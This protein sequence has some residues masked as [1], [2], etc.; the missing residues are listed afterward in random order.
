MLQGFSQISFTRMQVSYQVHSTRLLSPAT[1]LYPRIRQIRCHS[2]DDSTF[3]VF[4]ADEPDLRPQLMGD[5]RGCPLQKEIDRRCCQ[6]LGWKSR[7]CVRSTSQKARW[8][9]KSGACHGCYTYHSETR[10]Q[11]EAMEGAHSPAFPGHGTIA[12]RD[13][14]H[15][16]FLQ[17][18]SSISSAAEHNATYVEG[19]LPIQAALRSRW[20]FGYWG[21]IYSRGR[22]TAIQVEHCQSSQCSP[23]AHL[24]AD[25]PCNCSIRQYPSEKR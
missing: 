8:F 25:V 18:T 17:R 16:T 13:A 11:S 20:R 23:S 9:G 4:R 24:C 21:R 12:R 3:M 19:L 2:Y 1:K 22:S 10:A 15:R 7:S 6:L 14:A 5:L